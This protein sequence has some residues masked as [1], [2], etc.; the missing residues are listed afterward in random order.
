MSVDPVF[1]AVGWLT[2]MLMA[3]GKGA[4]GGG[5]AILSVPM[6][7]LVMDPVDAAITTAPLVSL[8]DLFALGAFGRSGWAKADLTWLIPGL[9]AGIAAGAAVFVLVDARIVTLIIALVTVAFTA[10]WFLRVR[11]APPAPIGLSAPLALVAGAAT[12]FSTFVAHA[13]GPPLAMYLLR[14]GLDKTRYAGTTVAVFTLGNL[15]KLVPYL[16]LAASKP[17]AL[18]AAFSFAPAAPLGVWLG[19]RLHDRLPQGMLFFWCY[20]LLGAAA[21]KL[22]ADAVK[23]LVAP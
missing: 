6:L 16:A 19:K 7:S 3:V 11:L 4:F 9:V 15:I 14:R 23:G 22:L 8:M 17:Q 1:L 2:T 12:G 10:H 5:L 13:G 18:W 21:L 20:V